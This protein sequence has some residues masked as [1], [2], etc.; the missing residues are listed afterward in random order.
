MLQRLEKMRRSDDVWHLR[1]ALFDTIS[2]AHGQSVARERILQRDAA[3][4][5]RAARRAKACDTRRRMPAVLT[6]TTPFFALVLLGLL[7]GGLRLRPPA[8]IP[9][10]NA[11]VLCSALPCMLFRF[12]LPAALIKL[13]VHPALVGGAGLALCAAGVDVPAFGLTMLVLAA[14]LPSAKNV[15][16]LAERYGADNGR[17]ARIITTSTVLAFTS[18]TL[19]AWFVH[20]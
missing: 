8:S 1:A 3:L 19:L 6:V 4:G 14:A 12:G 13:F 17:G 9:G 20:P 10:L 5:Q 16:L 7:T 15:S 2:Q 18:F 11:Y